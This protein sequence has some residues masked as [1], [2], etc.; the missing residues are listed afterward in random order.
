MCGL[1]DLYYGG[2]AV[3][4][5]QPQSFTCPL[6]GKMGFTELTLQEHVAAE[7]ADASSEVVTAPYPTLA[8]RLDALTHLVLSGLLSGLLLG[9]GVGQAQYK[10]NEC[11]R[12]G[13]FRDGTRARLT[14]SLNLKQT[15]FLLQPIGLK[16]ELHKQPLSRKIF[17]MTSV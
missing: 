13:V 17:H 3:S 6:C 15:P 4:V 7:H 14:H 2:E 12:V 1:A 10:G 9:F 5:E 11:W 16:W 8:R